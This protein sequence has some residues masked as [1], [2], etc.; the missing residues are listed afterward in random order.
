MDQENYTHLAFII[1]RSGS[2][3]SIRDDM[4]GGIRALLAS[5][6]ELE[7]RLT[8]D[9]VTFDDVVEELY[10][11]VPAAEITG[12]LIVPRG[13]TALLD[14]LGASIVRLKERLE[15]RDSRSRPDQVLVIVVTD[16]MENASTEYRIEQVRTSV[17]RQRKGGWEFVFLGA[18]IDS[19]QVAGGLGFAPS[20]TMDYD[21]APGAVDSAMASTDRWIKSFRT[22]EGAAFTDEERTSAN[23]SD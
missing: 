2:M 19:F 17:E 21:A 11:D 20:A 8:V 9:I 5:Q 1:D 12:D 18:N 22:G 7:G 10:T 3:E 6:A 23:R 16:G 4:E 13:S 15:A 14:A